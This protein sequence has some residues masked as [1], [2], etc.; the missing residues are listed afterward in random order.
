MEKMKN[1]IKNYIILLLLLFFHYRI[2]DVFNELKSI[3]PNEA[4]EI[5]H[6]FK[7]NCLHNKFRKIMR[8][9]NVSHTIPLFSLK[10]WSVFERMK[11]RIPRTQSPVEGWQR[12]FETFVGKY[13]VSVHTIIEEMKKKQI[14]I[15][16]RAED[17][18]CERAHSQ[19]RRVYAER[20]K[21]ISTIIIYK[22]QGKSSEL[23]ISKE[24]RSQH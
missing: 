20:E 21:R 9:G 6:W 10:C 4:S 15:K 11:L 14:Q 16:R 1:L 3:I 13:H 22:W 7:N 24:N 23:N 19:T 2:P 12:Y 18:I 5:M 8:G 17:L